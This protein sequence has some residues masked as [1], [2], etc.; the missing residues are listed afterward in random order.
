MRN[1]VLYG[2]LILLLAGCGWGKFQVPKKDYQDKVQVLGVMPLLVDTQ[3]EFDY[4]QKGILIDLLNRISIGKHEFLVE[5]LRGKKGYFDV[6][7]LP[8]DPNLQAM[9]L[10]T[11]TPERDSQGR[12]IGYQLNGQAVAQLA[13]QNVVDALLV[14]VISGAQIEE[15]RRSRN[16][17]ESLTTTYNDI[18]ATATVVD[19]RGNTLWQLD[20]PDAVQILLLQYADFDEAYFNR[21]DLVNV[22]N[23]GFSGIERALEETRGGIP[24]SYHKLFDRI[25]SGISPGLFDSL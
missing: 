8:G 12:P 18:V 23:I 6:R 2:L 11:S 17:L 13:E 9:S 5:R 21:T 15:K 25:V 24:E 1:W 3:A 4:P 20:G 19:S 16:L 7:P 10:L 22:K 14:V